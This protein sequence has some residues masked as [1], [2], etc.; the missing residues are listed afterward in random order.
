MASSSTK[1]QPKGAFA[2]LRAVFLV[3]SAYFGDANYLR[4]SNLLSPRCESM[5]HELA[6]RLCCHLLVSY[7]VPSRFWCCLRYAQRFFVSACSKKK[8]EEVEE[9]VKLRPILTLSNVSIRLP[10]KLTGEVPEE[11]RFVVRN[12]GKGDLQVND[13]SVRSEDID[14]ILQ[15]EV[16]TVLKRRKF[17]TVRMRLKRGL[18]AGDYESTLVVDTQLGEKEVPITA[19]ILPAAEC[20]SD[21]PCIE[22]EYRNELRKCVQTFTDDGCDD[23]NDCTVYDKCRSGVC[24]GEAS[25]QGACAK[26]MACN[27]GECEDAPVPQEF[28][29]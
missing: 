28:L 5:I 23:G 24:V 9:D 8:K 14:V 15:P 2:G 18:S 1:K 4:C 6:R 29:D 22:K 10:Q 21:D 27:P 25:N 13:I 26:K 3:G 11:A 19:I 12:T 17:V 20:E 7:L 16:P